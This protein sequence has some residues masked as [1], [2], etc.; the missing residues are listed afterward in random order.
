MTVAVPRRRANRASGCDLNSAGALFIALYYSYRT[1]DSGSQYCADL[2]IAQ[3]VLFVR[4]REHMVIKMTDENGY[5]EG[6]L[7]IAMP[8]MSGHRVTLND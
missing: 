3:G 6:Q 8:T 5:I 4:P 7:L 2:R 1:V